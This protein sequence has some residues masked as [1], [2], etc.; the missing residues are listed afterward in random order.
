MQERTRLDKHWFSSL[1]EWFKS[2]FLGIISTILLAILF[3]TL[4]FEPFHIPSGSMKPNLLVGDFVFVNK[5]SYGY[6]RY[7]VILHPKFLDFHLFRKTPKRGDVVVFV[8]PHNED[9]YY[10]KRV[11]GLPGDTITI[12]DNNIYINDSLLKSESN[13]VFFENKVG[14]E[15]EKLREDNL[16]KKYDIIYVDGKSSLSNS[17][18]DV[19]RDSLFVMG[20][21]RDNS[22][23]SRYQDDVGYIPLDNL[24]GKVSMVG[25]SVNENE[26]G[27]AALENPSLF[28]RIVSFIRFDR[29]FHKVD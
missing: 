25:I 11:V 26:G 4:F 7:S 19:P 3:R 29:L 9:V 23:D 24:V 28:K 12:K 6:S 15:V 13:G 22:M 2:G 1:M 21:N 27:Q 18:Y 16:T 17:V 14:K 10:V 8:P 5:M 20:D